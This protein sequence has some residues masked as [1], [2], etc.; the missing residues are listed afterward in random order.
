MAER[1]VNATKSNKKG[2]VGKMCTYNARIF[3]SDGKPMLFFYGGKA[4]DFRPPE[5]VSATERLVLDV[6]SSYP[7]LWCSTPY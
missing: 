6:L 3:L 7:S 1:R 4:V 5:T 2:R